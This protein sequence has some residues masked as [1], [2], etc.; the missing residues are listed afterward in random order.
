MIDRDNCDRFREMGVSRN[1]EN[2]VSMCSA[3][4]SFCGGV[5]VVV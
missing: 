2:N 1:L 3:C 5:N 4:V